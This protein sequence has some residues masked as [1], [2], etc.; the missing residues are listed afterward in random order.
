MKNICQAK[1]ILLMRQQ[2]ALVALELTWSPQP[3]DEKGSVTY[4]IGEDT[5]ILNFDNPVVGFNKCSIG[6]SILSERRAMIVR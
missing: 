2:Q 6:G 4:K 1:P 3:G 5:A